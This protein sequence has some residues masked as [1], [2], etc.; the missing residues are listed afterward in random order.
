MIYTG[1]LSQQVCQRPAK[2][3]ESAASKP[4]GLAHSHM[5]LVIDTQCTW[6]TPTGD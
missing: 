6:H 5:T 3:P 2:V 1:K 4:A